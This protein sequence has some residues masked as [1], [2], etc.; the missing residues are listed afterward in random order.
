MREI[1]F[2]KL[3]FPFQ[4]TGRCSNSRIVTF[5]TA[6]RISEDYFS[7]KNL[8]I[9]YPLQCQYQQLLKNGVSGISQDNDNYY[10]C[11][12]L[13][14]GQAGTRLPMSVGSSSLPPMPVSQLLRKVVS[15]ETQETT[16]RP[17]PSFLPK[18][19]GTTTRCHS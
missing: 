7:K 17:P 5:R 6:S 11:H 13:P 8:N 14:C 12:G 18:P 3:I 15:R 2:S 1:I 19:V 10:I 16:G 4:F 9:M